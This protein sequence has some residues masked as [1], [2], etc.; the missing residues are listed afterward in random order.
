MHV[1]LFLL[2]DVTGVRLYKEAER[3]Q[4]EMFERKLTN[5]NILHNELSENIVDIKDDDEMTMT[6][7]LTLLEYDKAYV[8]VFI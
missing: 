1:V 7:T 8:H 6:M 3:L 2:F 5:H 4:N